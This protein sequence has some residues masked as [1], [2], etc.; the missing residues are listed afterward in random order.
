M[1]RPNAAPHSAADV[2]R[3][4]QALRARH[5]ARKGA[6]PNSRANWARPMQYD[7]SGFPI[8]TDVPSFTDRV[9]RLLRSD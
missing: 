4:Q 6:G 5:S 1:A 7:E 8:R 9:R 3:F 2:L